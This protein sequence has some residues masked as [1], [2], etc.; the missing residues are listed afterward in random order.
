MIT[1]FDTLELQ[2]RQAPSRRVAL[3]M[4]EEGDALTAIMTARSRDI[5]EPLLVGDPGE[6]RR[7]AEQ[8]GLSLEGIRIEEAFG[9][10]ACAE[11]AVQ[12]VRE[13][14]AD[15]LMKGKTATSTI[16]KAALSKEK[17]IRGAGLLSHVSLAK[18]PG[19]HK[20]LIITD[21]ALNIAPTL[22]E[23]VGILNNALEVSRKLGVTLPKV[24]VIAAVE[25]VNPAMPVTLDAALLSKMADR[26][27]LKNCL[28]DGPFALDNALS[29]KSCEVKG[30]KTEVGGDVDIL[31]MPTIEAANVLYKAISVLTDYPLAGLIVGAAKP[32]I[33]TSRADSDKVK[34]YSILAGVSLA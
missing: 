18:P 20:M 34:Y 25:K 3:A 8:E 12:L 28:V 22:E 10:Y 31:L 5:V 15:C 6:I 1:D 13:G 14:E 23:K 4:A 17:G 9:E 16:M 11:R 21:A 29:S 7:V 30:I 19:Y 26:G 24:G 33:L 27:Q 32:I 2:A